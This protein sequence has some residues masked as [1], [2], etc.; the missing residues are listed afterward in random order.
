MPLEGANVLATR[1]L[2]ERLTFLLDLAHDLANE[3]DYDQ[4]LATV[5]TRVCELLDADRSSLFLIDRATNELWSRVIL[6]LGTAEIRVPLNTG[7]VGWVV[8]NGTALN[9]PVV[10][11][12]PRFNRDVDRDTGYQTRSILCMPVRD[13]KG[14]V[15]GAIEALNKRT[16]AFSAEDETLLRVLCD[17]MAVALANASLNEARAN[18]VEKSNILLGLMRSLASETDLDNLLRL[19]MT[20]TTEVMQADRSASTWLITKPMSCGSRLRRAPSCRRYAFHSG[21][22]SPVWSPPA[23]KS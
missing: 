18:E 1:S 5:V 8:T 23:A 17:H 4:L 6:P 10:D 22:V 21:W 19:I 14:N 3:H 2:A 13:S 15:I 12:D 20:R 7:I 9:V 16:G 11:D